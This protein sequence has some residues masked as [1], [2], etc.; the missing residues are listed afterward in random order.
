MYLLLPGRHHL[1]TNDQ[2]RHLT[3][4]LGQAPS[5][6]AAPFTALVWAITSA[7]HQNTR[8]NPLPGHRREA[9]IETF[10]QEFEIPSLVFPIDDVGENRRFA[11]Y[12]LKKIEVDGRLRLSPGDTVVASSTPEVSEQFAA[13]GFRVV[14]AEG[15]PNEAPWRVL[16]QLVALGLQG[17]D[18]SA[19]PTF[20][21]AVHRASRRLLLRYGYDRH[22]V[23]LHRHPVGTQDGD[24]TATR[25]YN[26]YVRAF[27]DGAERKA[28][29]VREHVRPGRIVDIGCCTGAV[30]QHL[31][32]ESRLRESDFYGIEMARPLYEEC[33]HRKRQGGFATDH[34]FFYQGNA[35]ERS[36]FAADSVDTFL[37]FSLTHELESYQGRAY[38]ERFL[39]LIFEQL[40]L[41]GRWINVDVVGPEDGDELV[42][43]WLN[44]TDGVNEIAEPTREDERATLRTQLARLSTRGR[45]ERFVRDFRPDHAHGRP[46]HE[47]TVAGQRIVVLP[48]RE[49]AEFLSK[50][51]Y[52]DNW[53]SEMHETFCFWSLSE[54]R[55]AVEGVGFRVL[56]MSHTFANPWIVNNRYEGKARLLR[57]TVKG[58]EAE[59]WPVTTMV[60]GVEKP[61]SGV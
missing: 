6:L 13:L 24:L 32:R 4:L 61:R 30:L 54:W 21:R 56:P 49:A 41:G 1:L 27:D 16:E 19:H 38:L 14:E 37:T 59:D 48:R 33:L 43:L 2:M 36:L 60:L 55:A 25:D 35:A 23:D 51:D 17:H 10:A 15:E 44:E 26:V 18:W 12:I 20:L 42:G 47:E 7:N 29:L 8:R 11:D 5:A 34:V 3:L 58:W 22:L 50:K 57:R 9:A 28:A 53:Q 52:L 31:C 45:F 39:R 46:Y 40:T